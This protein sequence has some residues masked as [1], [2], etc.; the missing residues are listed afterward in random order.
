M[1]TWWKILFLLSP[2]DRR[3]ECPFSL[4]LDLSNPIIQYFFVYSNCFFSIIFLTNFNETRME[5][6]ASRIFRGISES[7]PAFPSLNGSNSFE[8][9][10]KRIISVERHWTEMKS[11][12]L[13]NLWRFL[14]F[15]L[16][17]A[18]TRRKYGSSRGSPSSTRRK[19]QEERQRC[20]R[21]SSKRRS[22]RW[23]NWR[24]RNKLGRH[25]LDELRGWRWL[26]G[27]GTGIAPSPVFQGLN[28]TGETGV[29]YSFTSFPLP[30]V[31]KSYWDSL[32]LGEFLSISLCTN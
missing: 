14:L 12:F 27:L 18:V 7:S 25:R 28:E 29:L 6:D 17:S 13:T 3:I 19:N 1:I 31:A 11:E 32:H 8:G 24:F 4:S 9:V 22:H 5:K 21:I 16:L 30:L 23:R 20:Q 10:I 15:L 26:L 2:T